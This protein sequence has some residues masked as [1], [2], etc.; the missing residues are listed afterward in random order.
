[1]N[2][3]DECI[4][5]P[6]CKYVKDLKKYEEKPAVYGGELAE[7]PSVRYQ[8]DCPMKRTESGLLC[9]FTASHTRLDISEG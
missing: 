4:H 9:S 5:F 2:Y 3:C 8:I 7:G 6:V 1:M